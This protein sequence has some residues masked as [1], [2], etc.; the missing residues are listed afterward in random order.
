VCDR[1]G[2]VR[3]ECPRTEANP[4]VGDVVEEFGLVVGE[5][6]VV[7]EHEHRVVGGRPV[8]DGVAVLVELDDG[9]LPGETVERRREPQAVQRDAGAGLD[10]FVTDGFLVV[11]ESAPDQGGRRALVGVE[12]ADCRAVEDDGDGIVEYEVDADVL[13]EVVGEKQGGRDTPTEDVEAAGAAGEV[14]EREIGSRR[15]VVADDD[16]LTHSRRSRGRGIRLSDRTETPNPPPGPPGDVQGRRLLLGCV[17]AAALFGLFVHYGA[18][19]ES[20]ALY[21]GSEEIVTAY[22]SHVGET[23]TVSAI[24]RTT[25]ANRDGEGND[26]T[27]PGAGAGNATMTVEL[28]RFAS[29]GPLTVRGA[30]RT[31]EPGGTVNVLGTLEPDR[32]ITA[33]RVVRVNARTWSEPYKYAVS[34]VGAA[35][36]LVA[37]VREWRVDPATLGFEVRDG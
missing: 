33:Q 10:G 26:G 21:P 4:F 30:D 6:A 27:A 37:F 9:P 12:P 23:V 8:D 16:E 14:V 20:H 17:L 3:V 31:A 5:L 2:V 29:F 19:A 25:S 18:T 28:R 34:A 1:D 11:F 32:T 36:V 24:V 7:R 35:L 22:D 13:A 15:G